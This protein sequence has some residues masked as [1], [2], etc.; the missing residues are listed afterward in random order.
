MEK[1]KNRRT[2]MIVGWIL[3]VVI[4]AAVCLCVGLYRL[5]SKLDMLDNRY[6]NL[7]NSVNNV[8]SSVNRL[9]RVPTRPVPTA[10]EGCIR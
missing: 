2:A 10:A 8:S 4:V 7:Q 1:Q 5:S 3:L 6:N 9:L